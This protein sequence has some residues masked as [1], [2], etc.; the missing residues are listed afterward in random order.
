[1]KPPRPGND[2]FALPPGVHWTPVDEAH[3]RLR[4]ALSC[5][6]QV[7]TL[8]LEAAAGRF[9]ASEVRA[10]R[11]NPASSNSAVD[12]FGL[13]GP[14]PESARIMP[15]VKGRA[16]AG[17]PYN[18]VV[19][20]GRALRILTGASLPPGVDTVLLDENVSVEDGCITF[21]GPAKKGINTRSAGEDVSAGEAVVAAGTRLGPQHVALLAATGVATV[22]VRRRLRVGILST[23]NEIR[24]VGSSASVDQVFDANRPMLLSMARQWNFDSVDLGHVVD[25]RGPLRDRL[26]RAVEE[27]DAIITTGGASA[28]DEDHVSGLLNE[29][30]TMALWR[31]A[32][33]PGRPLALATWRG[34]PVFGL[35]GNPVA[36]FVC[37][38]LFAKPSFHLLAGG[39]WTLPQR[40]IVPA[41]FAKR[42]RHGRREYLRSRLTP[43]GA[44]EVFGSEGSGRISGLAW[45]NGLVELEDG[46]CEIS[47]GDPVRFLPLSCC[48]ID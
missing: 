37:A 33:K 12:G 24:P 25:G 15:L 40:F 16:A 44:A 32:I 35:P 45:A 14:V 36:A 17:S 31:I 42:K 5:V 21:Y 7:E 10:L 2:C 28:G 38:L 34:I 13:A 47:P 19:P 48:G 1:M 43:D 11:A 39:V 4:S 30:G 46:A 26:D 20:E 3:D 22:P 41:A 9:L 18:D 23:G 29:T 6:T 27:V 8:K